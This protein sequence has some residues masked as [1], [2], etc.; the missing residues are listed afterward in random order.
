MAGLKFKVT[1]HF[2]KEDQD[3]AKVIREA[4]AKVLVHYYPLAGRLRKA[5]AGKL[6]VEYTGEGV[7][8]VEADADVTLA[9]F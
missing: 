6:K 7:L 9:E 8:F 1:R 4:L 5:A 3:P 2:L